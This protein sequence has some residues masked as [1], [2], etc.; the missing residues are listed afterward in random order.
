MTLTEL[1]KRLKNLKDKGFIS[2]KRK[3]PTGI[4]YTFETELNLKETN[5]AI[6]DLGG[7][8]EL[9]TMRETSGSLVTL[10]TFNKSV[11][12]IHP[13]DA[14]SKYGYFD[15]NKRHCLYVTVAFG[16]PNN[17]GLL[18]DLDK[19][20]ENLQL[21]DKNGILIGNWKMSHIVAKFLSKMG[22]LIIVYADTRKN[23]TGVEEFFY[24]K[25]YLLENPSDDNFVDAIK[26]KSAFVDI[27]MYLRPDGSVRNHGT[28]FRVYDKDLGSLYQS[29]RQLI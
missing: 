4:G 27:R 19:S 22:R 12:K 18:L 28:G 20:G 25:A 11:W 7:R 14:I 8:I 5:I 23:D 21:K 6:P 10:F 24:K 13:K 9:K 3:G 29:R 16:T 26:K 1:K 15:E 17:Q 2:S